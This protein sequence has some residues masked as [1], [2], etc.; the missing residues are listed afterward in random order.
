MVILLRVAHGA[1]AEERAAQ[2]RSAA[3]LPRH[4]MPGHRPAERYAAALVLLHHV[5]TQQQLLRVPIVEGQHAGTPPAKAG[6]LHKMQP[7]E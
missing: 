7:G 3:A 4:G 6:V 5:Q 2:E 1:R